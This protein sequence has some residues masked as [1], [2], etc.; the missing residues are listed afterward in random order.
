MCG[1]VLGMMGL[2]A[3]PTW[4]QGWVSDPPDVLPPLTYVPG[5][6]VRAGPGSNEPYRRGDEAVR[7]VHIEPLLVM[8]TE[9]TQAQWFEVLGGNPVLENA[10]VFKGN[11]LPYPC[12]NRDMVA[13]DKPAV[14][15]HWLDAVLYANALSDREGLDPAYTIDGKQVTWDPSAR[16]YRLLT[17][18]E[19]EHA[20]RG[21]Q[22]GAVFA[23]TSSLARVCEYGNVG[24]IG[25]DAGAERSERL[26]RSILCH[27]RHQSLAPVGSYRPNGFG[28]YDMTGN[29]AE[30]VWPSYYRRSTRFETELHLSGKRGVR[31]GSW[32]VP[33]ELS[34]VSFRDT[35]PHDTRMQY[36][37]VR[38]GRSVTPQDDAYVR[39]YESGE[40][41]EVDESGTRPKLRSRWWFFNAIDGGLGGGLGGG[42]DPAG[43]SASFSMVGYATQVGPLPFAIGSSLGEARFFGGTV[44]MAS[45]LPAYLYLP[46]GRS[47]S[48]IATGN[49]T[50]DRQVHNGLVML[51]LGGSAWAFDGED[52]LHA[53]ISVEGWPFIQFAGQEGLTLSPLMAFS[54][55]AGLVVGADVFV[56]AEARLAIKTS[57]RKVT[58]TPR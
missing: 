30:W 29:A 19:W 34:R 8:T 4:A 52:Y 26:S 21:S 1:T 15:V 51:Q 36:V 31:G 49:G 7:S 32:I 33:P 56:Y 42:P 17:E 3:N 54:A 38:L 20:A 57:V 18:V 9:V 45:L 5:G 46:I 43:G 11:K 55:Q 40:P 16:G 37:G 44:R 39:A 28:L 50:S 24:E 13:P 41:I 25:S 23:G 10:A 22:T 6:K 14:C 53:A 12:K 48:H 47:V 2:L 27:D 58:V 35:E